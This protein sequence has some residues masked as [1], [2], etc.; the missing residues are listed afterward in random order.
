MLSNLKEKA[1]RRIHYKYFDI[2]CEKGEE[3]EREEAVF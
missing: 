2:V 1:G 3:L